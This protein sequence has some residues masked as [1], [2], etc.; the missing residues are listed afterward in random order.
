MLHE[1]L[2]MPLAYRDDAWLKELFRS[3]STEHQRIIDEMLQLRRDLFFD[4]MSER[5][6]AVEEQICDMSP[7]SDLDTRRTLIEARWKTGGKCGIVL[8]QTICDSWENGRCDVS[9]ASGSIVITFNGEHGVPN[10]IAALMSALEAAR[11]AHLPIR[12]T[13]AYIMVVDVEGLAVEQ[14]EQITMDQFACGKEDIDA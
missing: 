9:F 12:Y 13:F 3:S 7:V 6:T 8:L 2:L 4:T 5:Q 10:N 11:P 1:I 14:L